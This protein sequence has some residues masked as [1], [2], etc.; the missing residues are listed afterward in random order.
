L[1]RFPSKMLPKFVKNPPEIRK[2][3]FLILVISLII[4]WHFCHYQ[5]WAWIIQGII[6]YFN[7]TNEFFQFRAVNFWK[8][9]KFYK[10]LIQIK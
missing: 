9:N 2:F 4:T 10:I 8:S 5:S 1:F 3:I 6:Y 7:F